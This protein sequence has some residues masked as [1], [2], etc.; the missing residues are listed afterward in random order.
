MLSLG[1]MIFHY[2]SKTFCV[3][4][5]MPHE[6]WGFLVWMLGTSTPPHSLSA[7]T[8]IANLFDFYCCCCC[9]QVVFLHTCANS[10]SDEQV[11][12][13]LQISRVFC[14]C[15]SLPRYGIVALVSQAPQARLWFSFPV[16]WPGHSLKAVHW[17]NCWAYL[18]YLPSLMI[19]VLHFLVSNVLKTTVSCILSVF[20]LV[21]SGKRV[22]L[23]LITPSWLKVEVC[24][25]LNLEISF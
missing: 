24:H 4:Y 18:I 2:G 16:P 10:Y 11:R 1:L 8:V 15:S 21:I 7:G 19:T 13:T 3:L 14:L 22:N 17:G 23:I 25:C 5:I 9:S 12:E 6:L 20:F